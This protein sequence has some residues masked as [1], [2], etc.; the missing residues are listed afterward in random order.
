MMW[1]TRRIKTTQASRDSG[2]LPMVLITV[3]LARELLV[4]SVFAGLA[5]LVVRALVTVLDAVA[6]VR[7]GAIVGAR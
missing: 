6:R 2:R 4:V 5:D 1:L 3:D 7:L